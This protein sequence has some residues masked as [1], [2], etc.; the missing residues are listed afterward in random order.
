MEGLEGMEVPTFKKTSPRFASNKNHY[1]RHNSENFDGAP[2]MSIQQKMKMK[3]MR[4]KGGPG[5]ELQTPGG[6][7]EKDCRIF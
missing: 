3:K 6:G 5:G 2:G 1:P 7:D 4:G